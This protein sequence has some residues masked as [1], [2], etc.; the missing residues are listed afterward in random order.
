[1]QEF[2]DAKA[3]GSKSIQQALKDEQQERKAA[4]AAAGST[5]LVSIK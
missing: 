5:H 2:L 4:A 1:V 3:R